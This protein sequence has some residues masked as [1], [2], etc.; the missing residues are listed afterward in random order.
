MEMHLY[1]LPTLSQTSNTDEINVR[2]L[3][4]LPIA[5]RSRA[6]EH[7]AALFACLF[8]LQQAAWVLLALILIKTTN[9]DGVHLAAPST[10]SRRAS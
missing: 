7:V 5:T 8:V 3:T 4:L 9:C 10:G 1:I 2:V 6:S